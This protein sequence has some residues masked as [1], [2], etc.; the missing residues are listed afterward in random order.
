VQLQAVVPTLTKDAVAAHTRAAARG[1]FTSIVVAP[2]GAQSA[3]VDAAS[4][5]AAEAALDGS[6]AI[7]ASL[8]LL[9][10]P[11]HVAELPALAARVRA[12]YVSYAGEAQVHSARTA[13]VAAYFAHWPEDKL[14]ITDAAGAHLAS[15][16]LLASL[17]RRA[18]HVTN[19]RTR[20]D[21]HALFAV[22]QE[23]RFL[24]Q[25]HGTLDILRGRLLS[26]LFY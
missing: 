25:R 20:D 2:L 4:L 15:A 22:A 24:V 5:S 10:T 13:N 1:G 17:H 7:D 23:M 12:L 6:C 21:L 14:I 18:L 8:T 16:L 11:E 3:I 26:P 9:A 19:V